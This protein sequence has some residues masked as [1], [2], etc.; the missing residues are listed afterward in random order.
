MA[1]SVRKRVSEIILKRRKD[2][3]ITQAELAR[4]IGISRQ[5]L[6]RIENKKVE[7]TA[8]EWFAICEIT[9]ISPDTLNLKD[10]LNYGVIT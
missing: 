6:S 10:P 5:R 1:E 8:A 3:S 2:L 9:K 7:T 4:K